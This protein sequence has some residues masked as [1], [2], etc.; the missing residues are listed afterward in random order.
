MAINAGVNISKA[1]AYAALEL[2]A[3]VDISKAVAYAVL[4]ERDHWSGVQLR[5]HVDRD[6]ADYVHAVQRVLAAR[7]KPL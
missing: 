6:H 7:T 4:T 5:L 1:L 3:G 2:P